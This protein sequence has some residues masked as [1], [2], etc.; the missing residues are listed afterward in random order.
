M[1]RIV[2]YAEWLPI[3]TAP[4]DGTE[5]LI[6]GGTYEY[7][8]IDD[9]EALPLKSPRL[10]KFNENVWELSYTENKLWYATK[11]WPKHWMPLPPPPEA[12]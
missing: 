7:K 1:G 2:H 10:A 5:V 12:A 9:Q 8:Y 11:A 3:E 6:I 4:K